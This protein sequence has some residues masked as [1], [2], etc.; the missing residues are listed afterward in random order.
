MMKENIKNLIYFQGVDKLNL[1]LPLSIS[2]ILAFLI[3]MLGVENASIVIFIMAGGIIIS[4]YPFIGLLL[5]AFQQPFAT[6]LLLPGFGNISNIL[7]IYTLFIFLIRNALSYKRT[8]KINKVFLFLI[9]FLSWAAASILW[10]E[11]P[12]ITFIG[13]FRLIRYITL[14][15]LIINFVDSERRFNLVISFFLMGCLIADIVVLKEFIKEGVYL[16]KYRSAVEGQNPNDFAA[17]SAV[18]IFCC[19][20]FL[21][22]KYIKFPIKILCFFSLFFSLSCLIYSQ[23]RGAWVGFIC[24]LGI[25]FILLNK[26]NLRKIYKNIFYLSSSFIIVLYFFSD[27]FYEK[28]IEVNNRFLSIFTP[29]MDTGLILRFDIWNFALEKW[30]KNPILGIGFH[31]FH[32]VSPFGYDAHSVYINYLLELG[33]IGIIIWISI[34]FLLFKIANSNKYR[35]LTIPILIFFIIVSTKGTYT[36][37]G[38]YWFLFGIISAT[39]SQDQKSIKRNSE[40]GANSS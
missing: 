32:A 33:L 28:F 35:S 18:A 31:N 6:L 40:K 12:L 21:N 34:L 3:I 19:L 10:A 36:S 22:L 7:G 15:F 37:K 20:Y 39:S 38:F 13:L 25:Y 11:Y 30:L 2:I 14:Y 1:I 5:I 29:T 27:L 17:V 9:V 4:L 8:I 16:Y 26:L 24:S 23:S